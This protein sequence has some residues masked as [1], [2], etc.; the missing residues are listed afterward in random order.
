MHQF[1]PSKCPE[2]TKALFTEPMQSAPPGTKP[3]M[4]Y[5][6]TRQIKELNA[7]QADPSAPDL[8]TADSPF[9]FYGITIVPVKAASY[10]MLTFVEVPPKIQRLKALLEY[11]I[12]LPTGADYPAE[13]IEVKSL[14]QQTKEAFGEELQ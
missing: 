9:S 1:D 2:I 14:A 13:F 12:H 5:L 3:N 7:L 11:C 10:Y 6:G 8:T 4:L